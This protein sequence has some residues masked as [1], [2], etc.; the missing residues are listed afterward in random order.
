[1][2][3]IRWERRGK[4]VIAPGLQAIHRMEGAQ[5][6]RGTVDRRPLRQIR[7][8][9]DDA[10]GR[11]AFGSLPTRA[12]AWSKR[13]FGLKIIGSGP[14]K[15]GVLPR[16]GNG[17][18]ALQFKSV[19]R[20]ETI[21]ASLCIPAHLLHSAHESAEFSFNPSQQTD[22]KLHR[23]NTHLPGPV[24]TLSPALAGRICLS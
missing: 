22:T 17:L 3:R 13:V 10:T 8:A 2:C 12:L 15:E 1:M 7:R 18:V 6:R 14:K 24:W 19:A 20:Q 4:T 11:S 16:A 5:G 9:R 21:Y 23:Q